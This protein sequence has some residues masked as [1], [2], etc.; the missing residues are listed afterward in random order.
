MDFELPNWTIAE[1]VARVTFPGFARMRHRGED[2]VPAF[3]SALKLVAFATCPL[4]IVIS[5]AAEPIVDVVFG[6]RWEAMIGPLAV[7]GV[8][9]AVKPVRNT[10]A[11][12]L[13][14]VGRQALLGR[15]SLVLFVALVPSAYVGARAGGITG[16]A[17]VVLAESTVATLALAW[18]ARSRAAVPLARQWS[19]VAVVVL[20]CAVAWPVSRLVA[21]AA[22]GLIGVLALGLP[23]AAGLGAYLAVILLADPG[24]PGHALGQMRRMVGRTAA[25]APAS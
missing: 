10:I 4:G 21:E 23:V 8:W 16:V 1:S 24:L 25:A 13:N 9:G 18:F 3:L 17:W 7:L 5:G 22:D 20:A 6:P 2:V 14:S 19:A 12:L 15:V 11:W